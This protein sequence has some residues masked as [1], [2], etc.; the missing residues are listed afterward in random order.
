[1][2]NQFAGK[3]LLVVGG[4]SGMGLETA[5]LVLQQGGSVVIVGSRAQKTEQARQVLAAFGQVSALTAN[6]TD[7]QDLATLLQEIDQHH[8]DVDLLVNAAGVFFPKP[9]LEHQDA[10]YD[11]YMQLNRATFFITQK[12][13]ANLVAKGNPGA[14]VNIGSMWGKQAIAATPSSA[15]SMAKAGLHSLTQHLAMELASKHIRVNAVSPAV[16]QTPI[17]EGFIPKAEV[18]SALQGFNSFHPI[19]R[20]G[21]PEEV[22]EV[23]AFLLS[24]KASWVT[25]AVWDVDGGVM[26]G[27]N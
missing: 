10:D 5:R 3:K 15:Y 4:T 27:R 13:A 14:V 2:S 11:Q 20:V 6:L 16:V 19:G 24:E 7:V 17:Y 21:T 26:A 1:M 18:H 12:V 25:G 23:V 9:F 22:A 8:A